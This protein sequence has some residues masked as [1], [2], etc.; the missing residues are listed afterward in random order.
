MEPLKSQ[1]KIGP[2]SHWNIEHCFYG[3]HQEQTCDPEAAGGREVT[4]ISS[5]SPTPWVEDP[6]NQVTRRSHKPNNVL[7]TQ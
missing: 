6:Q 5:A 2:K 3:A 7:D 4:P 1:I